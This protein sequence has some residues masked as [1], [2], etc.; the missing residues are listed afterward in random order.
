MNIL[1]L[2]TAE[3]SGFV[4]SAFSYEDRVG[5]SIFCI[6]VLGNGILSLTFCPDID[7]IWLRTHQKKQG[8]NPKMS[9]CAFSQP[10]EAVSQQNK[11]QEDE[12]GDEEATLPIRETSKEHV[13]FSLPSITFLKN[14]LGCLV[15]ENTQGYQAERQGI[16]RCSSSDTGGGDGKHARRQEQRCE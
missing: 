15:S 13:N 10:T 5:A 14:T 6:G 7:K 8:K 11:E 1:L 4:S 2:F 3:W 9:P 16:T 12:A